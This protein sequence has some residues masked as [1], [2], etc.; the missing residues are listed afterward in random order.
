MKADLDPALPACPSWPGHLYP[1]LSTPRGGYQSAMGACHPPPSAFRSRGTTVH[2][3]LPACLERTGCEAALGI[4]WTTFRPPRYGQ[5]LWALPSVQIL[6]DARGSKGRQELLWHGKRAAAGLLAM[7]HL[8]ARSILVRDLLVA[9][10]DSH[11]TQ[12]PIKWQCY[13][14]TGVHKAS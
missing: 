13:R 10:Q 1:C 2:P 11:M 14:E 6:R 12:T 7:L 9:M 4:F 5:L 8:S 3:T